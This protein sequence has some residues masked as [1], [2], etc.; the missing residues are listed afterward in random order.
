MPADPPTL[1]D[2]PM[3]LVEVNQF[4]APNQLLARKIAP[5]LGDGWQSAPAKDGTT[6]ALLIGPDG[7]T[8]V[9]WATNR[10][11]FW[12]AV[13]R[14]IRPLDLPEGFGAFHW[15]G[16]D[17]PMTTPPSKI[18]EAIETDLLPAYRAVLTQVRA[19]A[20]QVAADN[21]HLKERA[22]VVAARLGADWHVKEHPD[23]LA[24]TPRSYFTVERHVQQKQV[25]G[26][27]TFKHGTQAAQVSLCNLTADPLEA[28]VESVV[29][30]QETDSY[31][32]RRW[33][34]RLR[35][36]L[37]LMHR[38][39]YSIDRIG[40]VHRHLFGEYIFKMDSHVGLGY[41]VVTYLRERPDVIAEV[42]KKLSPDQEG[43]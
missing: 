38:A 19:D 14:A 16:I 13:V 20:D 10:R 32:W 15:N 12:E 39:G 41:S 2:R 23:L 4:S 8:L 31:R 30:H 7:E 33:P 27:I 35:T 37:L 6:R 17:L 25:F 36:A 11:E 24:A 43:P 3:T 18:A 9:V 34:K 22:D 28:V 40:P 29:R 21:A 26:T 42:I 1:D 5:H